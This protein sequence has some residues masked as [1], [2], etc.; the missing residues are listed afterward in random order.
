M[1]SL[2]SFE[3]LQDLIRRERAVAFYC[4]TPTCGV[5]ASIKPKVAELMERNFP[6]MGLYYVD[7]EAIPEARG[8]LSVYSVPAVL[9]YF[10]GK[11][12]IREARNFGIAELGRKIERYYSLLFGDE[13]ALSD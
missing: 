7:T 8:Q 9:C 3:E 5:C 2:T 11:E 12:T 10:Q 1:K 13:G 6:S 4:S